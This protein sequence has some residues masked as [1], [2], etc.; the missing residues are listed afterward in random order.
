MIKVKDWIMKHP[1]IIS[2]PITNDTLFVKDEV[3]GRYL[4][5]LIF[6]KYFI[7]PT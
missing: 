7:L 5:L 2:S 4:Y 6:V 3:T 1:N